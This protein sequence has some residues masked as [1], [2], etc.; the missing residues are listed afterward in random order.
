MSD[1]DPAARFADG[2]VAVVVLGVRD[3]HVPLAVDHVRVE[4]VRPGWMVDVV[5]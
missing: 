4:V 3:E 1:G 5:P 2:C